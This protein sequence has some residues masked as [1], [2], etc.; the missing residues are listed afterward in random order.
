MSG[1]GGKREREKATTMHKRPKGSLLEVM[2]EKFANTIVA[3]RF[4]HERWQIS[5]PLNMYV[6]YS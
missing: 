3:F 6:E 5:L 4:T 2:G 1:V